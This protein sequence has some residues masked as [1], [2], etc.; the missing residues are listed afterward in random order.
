MKKANET[1]RLSQAGCAVCDA[2]NRLQGVKLKEAVVGKRDDF[3]KNIDDCLTK[4][5]R[6]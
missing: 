1:P 3:D 2:M 5:A 4:Q 6:L